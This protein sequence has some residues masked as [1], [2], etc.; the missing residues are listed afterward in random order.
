MVCRHDDHLTGFHLMRF[1][2]YAYL[3]PALNN[4]HHR[5]KG[6]RMLTQALAGELPPGIAAVAVNP[7]IIN[8]EMLRTCW[9]EAALNHASPEDWSRGAVPFILNLDEKDNGKSLSISQPRVIEE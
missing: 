9:G 5:I 3:R 2:V 4:T 1:P 6:R 8:T 7:G